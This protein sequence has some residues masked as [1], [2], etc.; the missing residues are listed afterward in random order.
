MIVSEDGSYS[1]TITSGNTTV[2][3]EVIG[4]TFEP[5]PVVTTEVTQ[6][7]GNELG[8]IS[9]TGEDDYEYKWSHDFNLNSGNLT[10]LEAGTY[11]VVIV[12]SA[13]C[14]IVESFVID[15]VAGIEEAIIKDIDYKLEGN[16]LLISIP[17]TI[18]HKLQG[19]QVFNANGIK[20]GGSE[21]RISNTSEIQV[22]NISRNQMILVNLI[23]SDDKVIKKL[24]FID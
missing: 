2:S 18:Q 9:I 12:N 3:S 8:T 10:D 6:I 15:I 16:E 4:L 14:A 22:P 19:W 20:I 7:S 5:I 24:I 21:K 11:S 13:G 23:F 17:T 1:A